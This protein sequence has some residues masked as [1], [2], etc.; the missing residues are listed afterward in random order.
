MEDLYEYV[1]SLNKTEDL[2][3]FYNDLETPG[4][5]INIPD[6]GVPV[7]RRRPISRNTHY[8]LT[9]AEAEMIRNDPRVICVTLVEL[10]VSSIHPVWTSDSKH[11]DKSTNLSPFPTNWGLK[12]CIDGEQTAN[13]GADGGKTP[14]NVDSVSFNLSGKNVD[15][16]I[17]DGH[18]DPNHPEFSVHPDGTGGSRVNQFDWFTLNSIVTSISDGLGQPLA[19]TYTYPPYVGST[20]LS[21]NNNHGCHVAGT[22]AGNTHGWARDANIYN[23][24]PYSTYPPGFGFSVVMWDYIRAFHR[25]KPI[26]PE[27]GRKNPTICNCSYGSSIIYPSTGFGSITLAS[28]RGTIIGDGT[29]PLTSAELTAAGIKNTSGTANIPYYEQTVETDIIDAMSEGIIVVAAAGNESALIDIP[30][31]LDWYNYFHAT[32]YGT[33]YKWYQHRGNTPHNVPYVIAVGATSANANESKASFSNTGPRISIFA[34]GTN[35]MS[36]F[37]AQVSW[38]AVLDPRSS[39]YVSGKISGTSM[40]SP[41]VCGVLACILQQYPNMYQI[42]ALEYIQHYATVDQI[43]SSHGGTADLTDMQSAP[44]LH[45]RAVSDRYTIN[46]VYPKVN[47]KIRPTTGQLYP[48]GK[49]SSYK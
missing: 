31:G 26:N 27:T 41:Q 33:N 20:E 15:V 21:D 1:I 30:T 43:P 40:A 45:L 24:C 37:N 7:H 46:S 5:D 18:I 38:P 28:H 48:R 14:D 12:R 13:W 36:S 16:I 10:I 47:F 6:R 4:G 2:N 9:H 19:S 23:I 35:I 32:Y 42:D 8:M 39:T 11:F 22:V 25:T 17:I 49:L 44:N 34:P 3:A 29:S